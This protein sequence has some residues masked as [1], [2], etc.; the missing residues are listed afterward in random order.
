MAGAIEV[1]LQNLDYVFLQL[2]SD[3]CLANND[4][5]SSAFVSGL[6]PFCNFAL[7]WQ[8]SIQLLVLPWV[9]G[10]LGGGTGD[11]GWL[12]GVTAIAIGL[13]TSFS[14]AVSDIWGRGRLLVLGLSIIC[15]ALLLHAWVDSVRMLMV[16]R[17]LCG[18]GTGLSIGLPVT[19]LSD[20]SSGE[21]LR[22][23]TSDNVIAY[24]I[25]QTFATPVGLIAV[26]LYGYKFVFIGIGIFITTL[27]A[28]LILNLDRITKN[29]TRRVRLS[30][31]LWF[32]L[33]RQ[34]W[35]VN[36]GAL[37]VFYVLSFAGSS[38]FLCYFPSWFKFEHD[39]SLSTISVFYFLS[40]VFQ[41][42]IVYVSRKQLLG[43]SVEQCVLV[44]LLTQGV[45]I[46]LL[47]FFANSPNLSLAI[48]SLI[49]SA[50]SVR[51]LPLQLFALSVGSSNEKGI[52][53]GMMN[54]GYQAGRAIGGTL[55]GLL[56]MS[57]SPSYFVLILSVLLLLSGAKIVSRSAVFS[58]SSN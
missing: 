11:V 39:Y 53:I 46:L 54:T 41:I 35:K 13:G 37:L 49:M 34:I 40:G 9:V 43:M 10:Q 17:L 26:K 16:L 18:F 1:R 23:K 38:L 30:K 52:R 51:V 3:T 25:G 15:I 28:F 20:F 6:M 57:D 19:I 27:V 7:S 21:Q 2:M 55:A 36:S 45:M 56:L 12:I 58:I 48:F 47:Y 4:R 44:S 14:G 31:F 33:N 8:N 50:L 24:M 5:A 22:C 42:L 32:Q 29:K